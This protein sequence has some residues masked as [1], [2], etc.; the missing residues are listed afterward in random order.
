MYLGHSN[1]ST[2]QIYLAAIL[3]DAICNINEDDEEDKRMFEKHVVVFEQQQSL[4]DS[5]PYFTFSS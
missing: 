5:I 3:Y 1:C 4:N 2:T